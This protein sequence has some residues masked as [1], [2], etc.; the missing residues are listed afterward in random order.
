[1]STRSVAPRG[2]GLK[3]Y[4]KACIVVDAQR[5]CAT[6]HLTISNSA[7]EA[8]RPASL[9]DLDRTVKQ[10]TTVSPLPLLHWLLHKQ[11]AA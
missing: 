9:G 10:G 8:L 4:A 11:Q 6:L 3:S 7:V 2:L 1:M 5:A